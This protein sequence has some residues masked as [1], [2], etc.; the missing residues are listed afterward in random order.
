M[1]ARVP[2]NKLRA[3]DLV[4]GP[5][6]IAVYAGNGMMWEAP[7]TGLTVRLTRVRN[8]MVGVSLNY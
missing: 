2:I 4:A 1:G 5:G 7:R 8:G 6:H 3:G